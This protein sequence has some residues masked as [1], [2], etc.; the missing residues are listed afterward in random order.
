[1]SHC[2]TR[3]NTECTCSEKETKATRWMAHTIVL[4]LPGSFYFCTEHQVPT[5]SENLVHLMCEYSSVA[6][7]PTYWFDSEVWNVLENPLFSTF[8]P[9]TT[10]NEHELF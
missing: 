3:H 2:V 8:H 5:P 1:M 10:N 9:L 6:C 4:Q 7:G